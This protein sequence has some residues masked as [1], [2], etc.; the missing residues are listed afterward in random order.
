MGMRIGWVEVTRHGTLVWLLRYS[1]SSHLGIV[2][3][4]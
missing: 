4:P 1:S 3:G 2:D